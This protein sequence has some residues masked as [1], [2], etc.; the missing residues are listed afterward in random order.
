[1]IE[2]M[3]KT[4]LQGYKCGRDLSFDEGCF[5]YKGR[6]HFCCYNPSKPNKWHLKFFEVS[7]ARTGYV[8]GF[9]VYTGKNKTRCA[10][11]ANVMDP[12]STQTSKVVIGLLQ[13]CNLL[14]RGTM[15]TWI[16]TTL[17]KIYFGNYIARKCLLV[18]HGD[19][20]RRICQRQ[21][22]KLNL[23]KMGSVFLGGMDHCFVSNGGK[24]RM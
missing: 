13:K 9:D 14:G 3:D 18:A 20:I 10:L 17:V 11:N 1:M 16:T 6:V 23:K 12:D 2:M 4:F 15:F 24:K 5:P 21:S 19:P 7:D 8:V 22:Q